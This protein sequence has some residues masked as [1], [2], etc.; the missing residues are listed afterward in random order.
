MRHAFS[1]NIQSDVQ[2]SDPVERFFLV[3]GTL[4][5]D[6]DIAFLCNDAAGF[7]AALLVAGEAAELERERGFGLAED[8]RFSVVDFVVT[9]GLRPA[10][11]LFFITTT[12]SF[13]SLALFLT[14]EAVFGFAFSSVVVDVFL[15]LLPVFA[16][17]A[18][19]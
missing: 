16:A 2:S 17:E 19:V 12:S 11:A 15:F 10:V 18:V 6:D 3:L 9:L 14:R 1:L 7:F 13:A 8:V 5:A 4:Y